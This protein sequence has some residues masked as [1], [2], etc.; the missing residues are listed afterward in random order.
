LQLV[1]LS[2]ISSYSE[3]IVMIISFASFLLLICFLLQLIIDS[4]YENVLS[5]VICF[6]SGIVGLYISSKIFRGPSLSSI[7]LVGFQASY[8]WL[9]LIALTVDTRPLSYN[10]SLPVDSFIASSVALLVLLSAYQLSIYIAQDKSFFNS[11]LRLNSLFKNNI[12]LSR[13]SFCIII[14]LAL[15]VRIFTTGLRIFGRLDFVTKIIEP[16]SVFG[17][18]SLACLFLT[19][20]TFYIRKYK[21][22]S[23]PALVFI[24]IILFTLPSLSRFNILIV[25]ANTLI[26]LASKLFYPTHSVVDRRKA[27]KYLI[28]MILAALL[29]FPVLDRIADGTAYVRFSGRSV[30]GPLDTAQKVV[31]AAIAGERH[32]WI[33]TYTGPYPWD[34]TYT[35]S[36]IFRRF[37]SVNY[38]D[39]SLRFHRMQDP[40]ALALVQDFEVNR[41]ISILPDPLINIFVPNYDKQPFTLSSF[42]DFNYDVISGV[43]LYGFRTGSLLVSLMVLFGVF[44][45]FALFIASFL[46]LTF[47]NLFSYPLLRPSFFTLHYLHVGPITVCL[48]YEALTVFTSAAGGSE[49]VSRLIE[50]MFRIVPVMAIYFSL[51]A[52]SGKPS[53]T[54]S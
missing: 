7:A 26:L 12:K 20:A 13:Q 47:F 4:S 32:E 10:L 38:L 51:F 49:S 48:M 50:L 31:S 34:D 36:T 29:V 27:S 17:S 6:M 41:I 37:I 42:G 45:P 23:Y 2:F 52:R 39:L 33:P 21:L 8:F 5:S 54:S 40:D 1:L 43:G 25:T 24:L 3:L 46:V 28:N 14:T 11:S 18:L 9:P 44:W 35:N 30:G 16:I 22:R 19:P 53:I 15:L